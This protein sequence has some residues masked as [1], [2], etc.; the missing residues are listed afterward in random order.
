MK[1]NFNNWFYEFHKYFQPDDT[2]WVDIAT[3][4]KRLQAL[5]SD[6]T[7]KQPYGVVGNYYGFEKLFE[8]MS[9]SNYSFHNVNDAMVETYEKTLRRA[10][11]KMLVNT[12]AVI[13]YAENLKDKNIYHT[14]MS[15][16]YTV[17]VPYDQMHF[18]ER[19]EFIRQK[20]Q[21]MN[22]SVNKQFIHISEF[23][24]SGL[25][26]IL[27]CVFVCAINGKICNDFYVGFNDYGFRF[28]FN[29]GG[30]ADASVI[31]YK[32][33]EAKAFSTTCSRNTLKRS[34]DGSI[35]IPINMGKYD[36]TNMDGQI[37]IVDIYPEEY[38]KQIQVVPNF[39]YLKGRTLV[40]ESFQN[41]TRDMLLN[42]PYG[43]LKIMAFATKH[44]HEING[45]FPGINYMNF[46][47]SRPIYT[48]LGNPV[49][50]IEGSQIIGAHKEVDLMKDLPIC[51]PPIC[52]D[53]EYDLKFDVLCKC[54][55]IR[56]S[57]LSPSMM[58]T[59]NRI[60][61]Y[62]DRSYQSFKE[63]VK[64]FKEFK[65]G[66]T[67][68]YETYATGCLLTSLVDEE[69]LL[70]F[71]DVIDDI[72]ALEEIALRYDTTPPDDDWKQE[73]KEHINPS[74]Y[75]EGYTALVDQ[76]A[77][78]FENCE[79]LSIFKDIEIGT[80]NFLPKES[81]HRYNRPVSEQCFITLQYDYDEKAYVFAHPVIQHFKGIENSFY[82]K[83]D[84]DGSEIY[85]F[86]VL[87]TD[88][89]APSNEVIDDGFP[90]SMILDYDTFI[91][92]TSNYIGF[93]R[94]WDVENQLMKLSKI[95]Y[96]VYN[97]ESVV[98]IISDLLK[99]E[100]DTKDLVN[101]YWSSIQYDRS[102]HTSDHWDTY[103]DNSVNAPF[104]INYLFYT[105]SVL[106]DGDDAMQS[107]FYRLLTDH[108]F[109]LRYLDYNIS[110]ALKDQPYIFCNF[111]RIYQSSP[112]DT[113]AS[114][115][116]TDGKRHLYVGLP[117]IYNGSND[118]DVNS[119]PYL[120]TEYQKTETFP[121]VAGQSINKDYYLKIQQ[122]NITDQ[123]YQFYFDIQLGKLC[124]K[125]LNHARDFI[126]HIKTGYKK[127]IEQTFAIE[128]C[129]ETLTKIMD[130]IKQ[131]FQSSDHYTWNLAS[132]DAIWSN[133]ID[134][135]PF[136]T[137]QTGIL[138]RLKD[139]TSAI[140]RNTNCL[141]ATADPWK[142]NHLR[143]T[144]ESDL[145]RYFL[146]S[147][148]A[149]WMCRLLRYYY[150]QYGFLPVSIRRIR[151]LY[152]YFKKF[153]RKNNIYQLKQLHIHFDHVYLT[154][155]FQ[156][157]NRGM[158]SSSVER[159]PTDPTIDEVYD[160]LSL[161]T[162]ADNNATSFVN[163]LQENLLV[164]IPAYE[165]V[166]DDIDTLQESDH[167][168]SIIEDYVN[169]VATSYLFDCYVID[170]II[171]YHDTID[172]E[173]VLVGTTKPAYGVIQVTYHDHVN[174]PQFALPFDQVDSPAT[175]SLY[176]H[177]AP[178]YDNDD[179]KYYVDRLNG[180]RQQCLYAFFDKE[181]VE[182]RIYFYDESGNVLTNEKVKLTFR[183][184]GN[185][186]DKEELVKILSGTTNTNVDLQNIHQ[187]YKDA[188]MVRK[189]TNTNY[190]MLFSNRYQQLQHTYAMKFR[191]TTVLPGPIDRV[192]ISNQDINQ[193]A[194]SEL[195]DKPTSQVFFKPSEIKHPQYYDRGWPSGNVESSGA[196]YFEGQRVYMMTNDALHYIFPAIIT[197]IDPHSEP[198]CGMIE[199][200]VDHRHAKWLEIKDKSLITTYLTSD[201]SCQILDDNI[202]N[203]LDEFS[204]EAYDYFTNVNYPEDLEFYD[205]T[206]PDL[207]SVPGD[208]IFVSNHSDYV[209]T[210]INQ[211][212]P[213]IVD[214]G[215]HD[216]YKQWRF[217]Y[218]GTSKLPLESIDMNIAINLFNVN[219][220]L[221]SDPELY[222]ILR[223]E[224]NDHSVHDLE[225]LTYEN[226]L[227]KLDSKIERY[228]TLAEELQ[229][230]LNHATLT[231][232]E[233]EKLIE[234]I[235][236]AETNEK[237]YEDMFDRV[238]SYI[239][240]PEHPT[241]WFNVP[242]YDA[243]QTYISNN[244]TRLPREYH[245]DIRD[246]NYSSKF[247]VFLYNWDRH[248]WIDPNTYFIDVTYDPDNP[249]SRETSNEVGDYHIDDATDAYDAYHR[250]T[251]SHV[252][253]KPH[254]MFPKA[255]K[256]LIYF[257]YQSSNLYHDWKTKMP[258]K[259]RDVRF[260]PIVS[261]NNHGP[262]DFDHDIKD[263]YR[264][265]KIRK[266]L[267]LYEKYHLS[268]WESQVSRNR[269]YSDNDE[270]WS[271]IYQEEYP[272]EDEALPVSHRLIKIKRHTNAHRLTS[273]PSNEPDQI[274]HG[275]D[276]SYTHAGDIPY[277]PTPRFC[278]LKIEEF[279]NGEHLEKISTVDEGHLF[280]FIKNPFPDTTMHV[281]MK[282]QQY[283]AIIVQ[284]I[285]QF[286]ENEQIKLNC[287]N[288]QQSDYNGTISSV[289]FIGTTSI[290]PVT[291]EQV[292]TIQYASS[293]V[294]DGNYTCSVIHD[295]NYSSEGGLIKITVSTR[296]ISGYD[297]TSDT[298]IPS[299]SKN[300]KW[301]LIP[302]QYLKYMEIPEEFLIWITT[303]IGTNR[304]DVVID[305][306]YQKSS[307]DQILYDNSNLFNPFEFYYDPIHK[308]RY[309]ISNIRHNQ[310]DRRLTVDAYD[311]T[312]QIVRTNHLHV[313]RY[314]CYNI[315]PDGFIDVTSYIPTPLSRSRYEFWVNGRQLIG[316]E[317]LIILSPTSF[318]LINLTSLKNF[319]LI[320]LVDDYYD[321]LLSNKE[322]IY[323][324]ING[325]VYDS[326]QQA[327]LSTH[328][329]MQ[330]DIRYAFHGF[331]NHTPLQNTTVG[332]IANP[333]NVDLEE[334][335]MD[336]W[337]D[338]TH[339]DDT[340]HDSYEEYYNIPRI[341]GIQLY[342]PNTD[343]IGLR[344]IPISQ[345]I[346]YFDQ[347]WKKERLTNPLFPMTH[348]DGSM[349]LEEQYVLL[350]IS[351]NENGYIIYTTGNYAK[352]FTLY[353]SKNQYSS[354]ESL[355][356]TLQ[357]IPFV[358]CGTRI[359]LDE[360]MHGYWLHATV[361]NYVS[362]KIQ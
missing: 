59:L 185:S 170:Q 67:C 66:L 352:Y 102:N 78:P 69:L 58:D 22:D 181:S 228:S 254:D 272:F 148:G 19:D 217:V 103:D 135:E 179:G 282:E 351:K 28:Q 156:V 146:L 235:K 143:K 311:D 178:T 9:K 8:L 38:E 79:A 276:R 216:A 313:C 316:N 150:Y 292:L 84:L 281:P 225:K 232:V 108:K 332:F 275:I 11:G 335:I 85:K 247:E 243:A 342:H 194:L 182:T 197:A 262:N 68:F 164:N 193:F 337:N 210:R 118:M 345:I 29:Y 117:S 354:I 32:L 277:V 112:I 240:E 329:I 186:A 218:M 241:T 174:Y 307:N 1:M 70:T 195:G 331:P 303:D 357:I 169:T 173:R 31:I 200:E 63:D 167:Y 242:S 290:D 76:L 51:T 229:Y 52:I 33:D 172:E 151:G 263:P 358:H 202:C 192:S 251:I 284:P 142:T 190:E 183:R 159:G 283:Q 124:A 27:D 114:I 95:L 110:E 215:L 359:Q 44:L 119:Y 131:L 109:N 244:R 234:D 220:S 267:D 57:M 287:I 166:L 155:R 362:K 266:H 23:T 237:K 233:R 296:N 326:Y 344:E 89:D 160:D 45:I 208:P 157:N 39:G 323:I 184:V 50:N 127:P 21:K 134:N 293:N 207:K 180:V 46:T 140:L 133:I 91:T 343:D 55:N 106:N 315:P 49:T 189:I 250:H 295:S 120:F 256:V 126:S 209:Y 25:S 116:S 338:G 104:Y 15:T 330:Q 96:G 136:L 253:I 224:P 48:D 258:S 319:E 198:T 16:R 138:D 317:H 53:R 162:H 30:V 100:I 82:I 80:F 274:R 252:T 245:F 328:E 113:T 152:I 348:F 86:F 36:N 289:L 26:D 334:N 73:Y 333:N 47:H 4:Y 212:F 310:F 299:V 324:D 101:K 214:P 35:Y 308:I 177:I 147:Q 90:E 191:K 176:F 81:S 24:T 72:D 279:G 129:R 249:A 271:R 341:N 219:R 201:I 286:R 83:K 273:S 141:F 43:D 356:H 211:T 13:F 107:E 130:E 94:Y 259:S 260:K 74:F 97:D 270:I 269:N 321:N 349:N 60:K 18:G 34:N 37:C 347:A 2:S 223:Q 10:M 56:T 361:V 158:I 246:I 238:K 261:T 305:T 153:F 171:V 301:I 115:P 255:C 99:G 346:P 75:M 248:E 294:H 122:S 64:T 327:F 360:S 88:T 322:P 40:L 336:T 20:I 221:L 71:K 340:Y 87:Y 236:Q 93:I 199:A 320:E 14:T 314:C 230:E 280:V 306:Q 288:D 132:S 54:V 3:R 42:H 188:N 105:L 161:P 264:S 5:Q 297:T 268:K 204:N 41:A 325:N 339:A 92:E 168:L 123:S 302:P 121:L 309:P 239:E 175:K 187:D 205:D 298:T 312:R 196:G 144:S 145:T 154:K 355:N 7:A 300:G 206:F 304:I 77:A 165:Q 125:Y 65:N 222:P 353:I 278:H 213:S 111:S 226:I 149:N 350:H 291:S 257:A 12:H 318:Q 231:D 163:A 62:G 61:I 98:H 139:T 6:L 203:F 137:P 285:D 227:E 265:L 128:S 17:D